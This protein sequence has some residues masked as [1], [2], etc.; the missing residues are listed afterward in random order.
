[1]PSDTS[2]KLILAWCH[3]TA[4]ILERSGVITP[5]TTH[6][7]SVVEDLIPYM[8]PKIIPPNWPRP[9][10]WGGLDKWEVIPRDLC[11]E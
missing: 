8:P 9:V 11:C 1:M 5:A 3:N 2:P 6:D 4:I 7:F 10:V